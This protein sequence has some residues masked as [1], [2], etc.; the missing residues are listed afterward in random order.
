MKDKNCTLIKN[1]IDKIFKVLFLA[2]SSIF[3]K[4]VN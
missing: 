2:N 4:I 1:V 3:L